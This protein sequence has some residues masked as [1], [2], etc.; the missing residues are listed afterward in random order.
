MAQ[1]ATKTKTVDGKALSAEQFAYVGDPEDISTWHLPIDSDHIASALKMFGHEKNVPQAAMGATARKIASTAKAAGLDTKSFEANYLHAD[2]AESPWIQIFR[3]GDYRGQGKGVITREDLDRV[4]RN[5]NPS[6]HEAPVT[7][8]HPADNLPAFGWV[9]RLAVDGDV[10]LAKEK[11]VDPQFAELRQAGR[12]KKRSASFYTDGSGKV[13]GLRHVAYL[14]AQPPAVKGLQDVK[15][16]DNGREFI[17]LNFGEE[18]QVEKSVAEQIKEFF[19]PMFGGST[20]PKNFSEDDAKRI[21][22]EA[23]TAA[24]AP[25]QAK[26]I[27]LE[28]KLTKQASDFAEREQR[29]A[30]AELGQRTQTAVAALKGSGKWVPAFEKAGLPLIFSEL[31]KLTATVEFGEGDQKKQV[32]PFDLLVSFMEQLPAIVPAGRM[33]GSMRP[34]AAGKGSTG[35]VFTDAVKARQKEKNISFEEA[36]SQIEVECP[37]L[38]RAGAATGGQV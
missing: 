1:V 24:A 22:A 21:A 11:Q 26:V 7:V 6:F 27:E 29:L 35:D 28:T 17:E 3:A 34:P 19:A 18:S 10:L 8:G 9:D 5:Y 4:V 31:A 16:D 25:L 20:A 13:T 36:M 15:F 33:I 38:M 32:S 37:E 23:A 2:H 30:M 12:Y 14:G